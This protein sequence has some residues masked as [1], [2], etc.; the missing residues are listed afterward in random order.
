MQL[1]IACC[2]LLLLTGCVTVSDQQKP[3][4]SDPI[5][6]SE[7]RLALAL[8]YIE[9]QKM[10]Q[11]K[12]NIDRALSHAPN[13]YKAQLS[14]A[15]YYERV[16]E[17]TLAQKAYKHALKSNS[18]NG[19][20]LN[21]YG[22]FLCKQHDYQQADHYLI[23]ATKQEGYYLSANSYE[24]AGLCALKDNKPDQA[25][26]YFQ[27][28]LN[29]EPQRL[30]STLQLIDLDIKRNNLNQAKLRVSEL[31]QHH[32]PTPASIALMMQIEQQNMT[33]LIK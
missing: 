20:V 1:L 17:P 5:A 9:A 18:N 25:Y 30:Q 31:H 32:Q 10:T 22:T 29:H 23:M 19:Y 26:R 6:M 14:L 12:A 2:A 4:Q 21:N 13:Y 24:N 15:Y 16:N 8:S 11:A 28:A 7:A 27:H 3:A 33:P